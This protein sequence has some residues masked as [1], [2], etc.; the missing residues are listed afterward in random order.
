MR[1]CSLLPSATEIVAELGLVDSLV[2]ISEECDWPPEVRGLPV[3]TASRVATTQVSSSEIDETVRAAVSDGR[4]LYAIDRELLGTLRPDLILTQN[5]CAVCAVS[6]GEVSE[7]CATD[8]EILA[9]D[10]HTLAEIEERILSLADLLGVLARGR[11]VVAEMEAKIA[12]VRARVADAPTR[13]V[14]VAEWLEPPYA[15][16]HWIPEMV[17]IAGGRDILGQA[18]APS[19]PTSWEAVREARPELV[20][21]APC[22]F[23]H[24]RAA[25]E[26]TLLPLACRAVAVDSNAYYARPAPRLADGIAQL[27]F[28]IH[29]DLIDDPGLPYVELATPTPPAPVILDD[30]AR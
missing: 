26:A 20:V 1:I 4:P 18:G 11:S 27:A 30:V 15:A 19:Y 7:L 22:G 3:V 2:G 10:A 14:F 17:A 5:L 28:L 25:R 29:P 21:V 12:A 6:A 24:E 23:D 13:S 8:A 16:G 9:L